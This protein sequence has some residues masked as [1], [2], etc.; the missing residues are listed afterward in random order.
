MYLRSTLL[1][2]KLHFD[3]YCR[4]QVFHRLKWFTF[5][6]RSSLIS[7]LRRTSSLIS[8]SYSPKFKFYQVTKVRHHRR[9]AP[10]RCT[11]RR[12][13]RVPAWSSHR[14]PAWVPNPCWATDRS[15]A[16]HRPEL[17]TAAETSPHRPPNPPAQVRP[18]NISRF[19]D[20]LPEVCRTGNAPS[21]IKLIMQIRCNR[22]VLTFQAAEIIE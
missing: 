3:I 4:H 22:H 10:I 6:L 9:R 20:S 17:R 2:L 12:W 8:I 11:R 19:P 15:T 7:I 18:S 5:F 1:L 13:V 21:L 16:V 14:C